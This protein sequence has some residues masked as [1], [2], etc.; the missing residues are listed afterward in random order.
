MANCTVKIGSH[1]ELEFIKG[2][3]LYKLAEVLQPDHDSVIVG[4]RINN[5]LKELHDALK[6]DINQV[7]I[8]DLNSSDGVRIYQRSLAF[9]FIRAIKDCFE[10]ATVDIQHSLSGGL[11]CVITKEQPLSPLDLDRVKKR[12]LA[13]IALNEVFQKQVVDTHIAKEI[14]AKQNQPA[15]MELLDYRREASINLYAYGN[16]KDYFY[17]Y[18]VYSAGILDKFELTPYDGGVILRHPTPFS[19]GEVPIYVEQP[20]IA[21][22][23][24]EAER[25]GDILNVGYLYN[26]NQLIEKNLLKEQILITEALQE[27]KIAEIADRI[28]ANCKR[29]ILIA[30]PS[31][32]GKT[33]FANRLRIQLLATGLRPVTLSTDDYFVN[34]EFTPVDEEGKYDFESIDAV[35]LV[36]FN[37]DLNGL[38]RGDCVSMP[39]FN[40]H[41]GKRE[42]TGRTLQIEMGQPIIIE[43]IHGLNPLLTQAVED[44]NKFRIYISCLTQ[45]N[46]DNHNRIPTTDSRLIRRIVRDNKYR[47]HNALT[48]LKLWPSVRR[49]EE[50]NIFPFQESADVIF[51]SAMVY[52]LAVLKKHIEPLLY[53]IADIETEY[54]EAKRLLKFLSYVKSYDFDGTIP[55]TS[56]VREFI[57]GNVF[58][59]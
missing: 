10:K 33:T 3:P 58:Y 24:R 2:M 51:N 5:Q 36:Q 53:N 39:T 12:M 34:R 23:H 14:F 26:I 52:E 57:G 13:L 16:L 46:I 1:I 54:A 8:V 30:G 18:M 56:I 37:K 29:L 22:I 55:I 35:D 32:S 50:R 20:K 41:Q 59:E 42:Y 7:S 44:S 4:F 47:G 11:F 28:N 38:L 40:F 21:E 48:T 17:G 25:W 43:G 6:Y 19:K 27:K 31:S 49:G 45:L 9:V 15:T